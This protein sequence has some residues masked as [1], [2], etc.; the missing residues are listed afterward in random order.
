MT[1]TKVKTVTPTAAQ[2]FAA[3]LVELRACKEAREWADGKTAQEAWDTCDRA[4]W[5]LWW[6]ARAK[7]DAKRDIVRVACKI[8]RLVLK[9]VPQGEERPRLAIEAAERWADDPTEANLIAVRQAHAA[10]AAYA[11]AD[12][13]ADARSTARA[14]LHTQALAIIRETF[15]CPWREDA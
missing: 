6:V 8:A 2:A 5:L 13:Y 10:A 11:A 14:E 1:K 15:T 12:A 7:P 9:Y 3:H 4:D